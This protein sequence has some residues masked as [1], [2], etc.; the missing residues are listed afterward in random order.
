MQSRRFEE[1]VPGKAEITWKVFSNY[2]HIQ[3][4]SDSSDPSQFDKNSGE[5][6][7]QTENFR[8]SNF[9]WNCLVLS[10]ELEQLSRGM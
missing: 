2:F 1:K 7:L 8:E 6:I 3:T 10:R 5:K 9:S 4:T